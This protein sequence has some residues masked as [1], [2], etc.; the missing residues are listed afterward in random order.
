[1]GVDEGF[2]ELFENQALCVVIG[3]F[4]AVVVQ[5]ERVDRDTI[6]RYGS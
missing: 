4:Y 5:S 3:G 6:D 1:M 2:E